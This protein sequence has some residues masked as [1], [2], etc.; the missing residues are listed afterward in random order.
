MR[1]NAEDLIEVERGGYRCGVCRSGRHWRQFSVVRAA[2]HEPVVLCAACRAR[3]GED[4]PARESHGAAAAPAPAAAATH[5]RRP[6]Q[7][8]DRLRRVLRELPRGEHSTGRIAKAAGLNQTKTLGRLRRLEASGE[9]R[10][11]G[12]RWSTQR[13]STDIEGAFDRLQSSTSNIRIIREDRSRT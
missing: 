2:G 11:V 13:P 12:K 9:V 3:Y 10:R 5:S 4:P 6:R 1:M 7:R 8:E